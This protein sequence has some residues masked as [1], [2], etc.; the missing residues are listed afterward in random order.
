VKDIYGPTGPSGNV[1]LVGCQSV[2][3]EGRQIYRYCRRPVRKGDYLN[4]VES[5]LEASM[6]G[7]RR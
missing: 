6:G 7:R 4:I 2:S 5:T 1:V 3:G